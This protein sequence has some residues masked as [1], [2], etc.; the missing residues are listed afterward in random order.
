VV[1]IEDEGVGI[2][3]EVFPHIT[4]PFFTT[5][6]HSGGIGL[7]LSISSRIVKEHGGTLTFTSEPGRGTTAEIILPVLQANHHQRGGTE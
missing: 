5:K 6:S 1:K 4:D 7:G 2:P 3:A